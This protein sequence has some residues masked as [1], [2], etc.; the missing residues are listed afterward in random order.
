[1]QVTVEIVAAEP[2]PPAGA[3][4]I[5]QVRDAAVA[6]EASQLLGETRATWSG[7]VARMQVDCDMSGSPIVFVH[8]DVDGDGEIS[9]GDYITMQSYPVH[10]GAV[11]V[12]VKKV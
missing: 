10:G 8:V 4:V 3:A 9:T 2:G 12:E 5:V 6:D 11:R 1:M 7:A